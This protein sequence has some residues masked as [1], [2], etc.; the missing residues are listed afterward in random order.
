MARSPGGEGVASSRIR[1]VGNVMIDTLARHIGQ[2]RNLAPALRTSDQ[3]YAL[4]TLHRP[5]NVDSEASLTAITDF[6]LDISTRLDVI[7][8]V[9][10][11]TKGRLDAFGLGEKLQAT[12]RPPFCLLWDTSKILPLCRGL[13]S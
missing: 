8:P 12:S 2:A 13:V 11:R 3:P 1:Y 5:S 6:L 10:P 4:V 7:F 9:H